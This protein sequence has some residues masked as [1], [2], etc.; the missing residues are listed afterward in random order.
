MMN[1][2]HSRSI[3]LMVKGKDVAGAAVSN[4]LVPSLASVRADTGGVT[5]IKVPDDDA[6]VSDGRCR[7]DHVVVAAV[8]RTH[9]GRLD[10]NDTHQGELDFPH[11]VMD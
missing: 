10:A 9:P 1:Y 8:R 2:L 3:S 7:A 4:V 5:G 6:L 11:F